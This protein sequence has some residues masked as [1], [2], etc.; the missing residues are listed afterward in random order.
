M[1]LP[2][3]FLTQLQ[4]LYPPERISLS[5]AVREQHARDQSA[6]DPHLPDVV[7]WPLTTEEVSQTLRLAHDARVPVTPWGAGTSI[8]G[9]PIPVQGGLV[10]DF[11]RMDQILAIHERDFQ[12]TVQPGV[13]YKDMNKILA[14]YGLFFAPDPGANASI[15]GMIANNAAG[16]RTVKYGATRDNVLALEVVLADGRVIRTGSRSV[17]QSAGYDLTHLFVGSEGTLGVITEAT[18]KLAPIPAHVSAAV[19]RFP[20]VA[21]AAAAV[22]D[23]IGSGLD[24]TALELLDATAMRILNTDP[25]IP[26]FPEQPTLFMEFASSHEAALHDSLELVRDIC[27]EHGAEGFETGVSRQER[28]RIWHARHHLFE[29]HVR[30]F[31]G[32]KF[33]VGDAAVPISHYPELIARTAALME[34]MGVV[35]SLLGHAGDGN[36]HTIVFYPPDDLEARDRALAFNDAFVSLALELEGTC[37]GEHGVGLGKRKFM[38]KEHGLAIEVMRQLKQTLD[39]RGIL[40]PGKV[41]P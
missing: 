24:P 3:D 31:S 6:H 38:A 15:G 12:V 20:T 34:E 13:L 19:A 30:Y 14:R 7:V 33:L 27:Q 4:S 2:T 17:K 41:L 1:S 26:H 36:I 29:A 35:G 18:L 9:N 23:I 39:P 11:S 5:R 8:E 10:M 22:F 21:D 40:N 25:D 37:T 32:Q 16:I 28:A